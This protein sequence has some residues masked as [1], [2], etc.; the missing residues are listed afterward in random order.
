MHFHNKTIAL[1]MGGLLAG[2]ALADDF[3]GS[4]SLICATVEARDCVLESECF[5]GEAKQ[6]GAPA[7]FRLDFQKKVIYGPERES[8]IKLMEESPAGLLLQGSEIGYGL[9]IGINKQT[10]IFSASMTNFEGSFLLFG[11]CT[12]Q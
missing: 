11:N 4:K 1:V 5:T 10:G 12:T 6:V 2:T 7:F 3:D 8:P 9:S